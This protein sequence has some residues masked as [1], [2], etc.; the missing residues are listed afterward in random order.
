MLGDAVANQTPCVA[1]GD[2]LR[3]LDVRF[4]AWTSRVIGERRGRLMR[5]TIGV[6]CILAAVL[7]VW[8]SL[9]GLSSAA[10][11]AAAVL[12][13]PLA[14]RLLRPSSRQSSGR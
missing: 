6:L 14:V 3:E 8:L 10:T 9:A 2:Q 13:V 11:A 4:A 1:T 12:L 7:D 5:Q